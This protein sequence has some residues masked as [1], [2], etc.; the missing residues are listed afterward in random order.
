MNKGFSSSQAPKTQ[1]PIPPTIVDGTITRT[2]SQITPPTL[3]VGLAPSNLDPI[4]IYT[5]MSPNNDKK[6]V[7]NIRLRPASETEQHRKRGSLRRTNREPIHER[8]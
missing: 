3:V 1:D 6:T 2:Y 5:G 4:N 7:Y 8:R